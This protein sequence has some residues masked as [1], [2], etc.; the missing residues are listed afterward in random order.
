[1]CELRGPRKMPTFKGDFV[2]GY[3]FLDRLLGREALLRVAGKR[4]R[5]KIHVCNNITVFR[6]EPHTHVRS[7]TKQMDI[8]GR[9]NIDY[10]Y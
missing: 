5:R 3:S 1:M 8:F 4:C 7:E 10:C 9:A 6:T 2:C